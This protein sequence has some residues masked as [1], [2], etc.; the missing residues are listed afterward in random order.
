VPKLNARGQ[1]ACHEPKMEVADPKNTTRGSIRA[2]SK[3]FNLQFPSSTESFEF[4]DDIDCKAW[5]TEINLAQYTETFLVNLSADQTHIRR[6]RLNQLRQQ[7]LSAMNITNFAHQKR[8]MEHVRLVQRFPFHSPLRK[9]EVKDLFVEPIVIEPFQ[10]RDLASESKSTKAGKTSLP[11]PR[12]AMSKNNQAVEKKRQARRRRSF[13]ADVWNSISN[14]RKKSVNNAA[15]A[16]QLRQGLFSNTEEPKATAG[17]NEARRSSIGNLAEAPIPVAGAAA[18][19][20]RG[21]RWSFHG[22]DAEAHT[23]LVQAGM[24]RARAMMYGNMALEYDIMLTNL[25][26]LQT[27]VL[28]KFKE[29]IGCEVASLFF[30]NNKTRELL[31]CSAENRWYRVPFG[32]GVCGFCMETGENVNIPDAYSDYRFNK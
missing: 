25:H 11:T 14:M 18:G 2:E 3:G 6:K 31:L 1:F 16:D 10:S 21:R 24:E 7:D 19:R 5:L 28:N 29:T 8:I 30:V 20:E 12:A 4:S 9:K 32:V 13:D 27:D 22:N 15:M 23:A 26:T 17:G